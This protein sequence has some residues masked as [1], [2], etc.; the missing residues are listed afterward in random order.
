MVNPTIG[1]ARR[2]WRVLALHIGLVAA[3]VILGIFGANWIIEERLVKQALNTES[4]YY[5]NQIKTDPT[6][7]LPDTRN[8][9]GYRYLP[10][11]D[12]SLP[13]ALRNLHV[14]FHE[15]KSDEDYSVVLVSELAS[16]RLL[17]VFNAGQVRQLALLFGLIPLGLLL[18]V[19]YGSLLASYRLFRRSVSPVVMLAKKVENLELESMDSSDFNVKELP[20]NIDQ[21]IISLTS[22]LNKLFQRIE[23]FVAREREF[24]RNASHELRTPLTVINIACGLLIE[25]PNL[26]VE[27]KK[28]VLRIKRAAENMA[29]LVETFLLI[30]RE[31]E[32]ELDFESVC[33][34][35]VI[36]AEL[37]L[38]QTIIK[39]K[40]I[41]VKLQIENQVYIDTNRKVLSGLLGN[42]LRNAATYTDTGHIHIQT[43]KDGVVIEDTGIG[44]TPEEILRIFD[45]HFQGLHQKNGGHGIGMTIAKKLADRFGWTIT[46]D[47]SPDQGTRVTVLFSP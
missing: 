32:H 13:L 10:G 2:F 11:E 12:D 46:V 21:E 16:E 31:M 41:E 3:A 6:F 34:N 43:L 9:T 30:S 35:D 26:G 4:E 28:S 1:I 27:S 20:E 39:S 36:L 40:P 19:I 42:L 29:S 7:P 8:L 44:M 23:S 33:V 25:E 5:W 22:A 15:I 45:A 38:I 47:S 37:D 14:G 18:F 17:L 24:T